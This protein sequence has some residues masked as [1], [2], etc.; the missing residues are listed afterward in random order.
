MEH[1]ITDET[2]TP[3]PRT[4]PKWL[5]A[6]TIVAAILGAWFAPWLAAAFALGVAAA[7]WGSRDS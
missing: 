7:L 3:V 2:D 5:I 1:L 6:V 4:T